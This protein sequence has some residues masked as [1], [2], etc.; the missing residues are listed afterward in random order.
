MPGAAAAP[1]EPMPPEMLAVVKRMQAEHYRTWVDEAIPALGG[2]TPRAA[3]KRKGA[4]REA[5]RLLLAEFEHGEATRPPAQRIDVATLR[6][7]LG[8][9]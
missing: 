4:P 1:T 2:L 5:L 6:R 7:E 8:I 9:D 3:A